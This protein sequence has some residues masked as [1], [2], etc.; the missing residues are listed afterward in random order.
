MKKRLPSGPGP[1]AVHSLSCNNGQVLPRLLPLFIYSPPK[2]GT[3]QGCFAMRKSQCQT[4]AL[5]RGAPW[6]QGLFLKGIQPLLPRRAGLTFLLSFFYSLST[7]FTL[8]SIYPR[9]RLPSRR[10]DQYCTFHTSSS[11]GFWIKIQ[12]RKPADLLLLLAKPKPA[13]IQMYSPPATFSGLQ[14]AQMLAHLK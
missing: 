14:R 10:S 6:Q 11:Y 5:G 9:T 4:P 1:T 8:S 13:A 3:G 2:A 7:P 12:H